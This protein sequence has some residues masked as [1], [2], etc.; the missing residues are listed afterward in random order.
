MRSRPNTLATR[1]A[2]AAGGRVEDASVTMACSAENRVIEYRPGADRRSERDPAGPRS[3]CLAHSQR[4]S[5]NG[6]APADITGD[7]VQASVRHR[8]DPFVHVTSLHP[9]PTVQGLIQDRQDVSDTPQK[10]ALHG[11]VLA[12]AHLPG[13]V[14][15]K[16]LRSA[17]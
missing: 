17:K 5:P 11:P 13:R 1:S 4:D 14:P 2:I 8:V 16:T 12:C 3:G 6:G 15:G 9:Q 10:T 7:S